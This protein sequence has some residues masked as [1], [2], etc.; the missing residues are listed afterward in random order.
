MLWN[1]IQKNKVRK[2]LFFDRFC[3]NLHFTKYAWLLVNTCRWVF[4]TRHLKS[5][6]RSWTACC[7]DW[8]F[9]PCWE[10]FP[11][12]W[13]LDCDVS[14][15]RW[16]EAWQ[17]P[18]EYFMQS[19]GGG[20]VSASAVACLVGGQEEGRRLGG[21]LRVMRW[22]ICFPPFTMHSLHPPPTSRQAPFRQQLSVF[23]LS[24]L[25]NSRRPLHGHIFSAF[26]LIAG[27]RDSSF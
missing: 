3:L 13:W 4:L 23:H 17:E 25:V 11:E 12:F 5:W 16:K 8:A 22:K 14:R 7:V 26:L 1:N 19:G 6:P 20:G 24:A 9:G 18:L 27:T 10:A 15:C 21:G 2:S